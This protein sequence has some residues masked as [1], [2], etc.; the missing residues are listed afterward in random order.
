MLVAMFLTC[1]LGTSVLSADFKS[2]S[3]WGANM[4]MFMEGTM[5]QL[6]GDWTYSGMTHRNIRTLADYLGQIET[7]GRDKI[8]IDCGNVSAFDINGLQLLEVWMQCARYMGVESELVNMPDSFKQT[9]IHDKQ[10]M[11]LP[12]EGLRHEQ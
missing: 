1:I 5:A 10:M 7:S 9:V 11:E 2:V 8:R 6:Q 4:K 12:G 3:G